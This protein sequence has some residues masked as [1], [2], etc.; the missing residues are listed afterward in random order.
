MAVR[1]AFEFCAA[2]DAAIRREKKINDVFIKKAVDFFQ[3]RNTTPVVTESTLNGGNL[4]ISLRSPLRRRRSRL[5]PG[6]SCKPGSCRRR[7]YRCGSHW[8]RILRLSQTAVGTPPFDASREAS[9]HPL[10]SPLRCEVR[11]S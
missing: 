8:A 11:S 5:L 7:H 6:D 10:L 3:R 4:K 9:I 2:E 1:S